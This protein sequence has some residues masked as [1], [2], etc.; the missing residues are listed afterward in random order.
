[1]NL[2]FVFCTTTAVRRGSGTIKKV[3]THHHHG[4]AWIL[5][6]ACARK[7]SVIVVDLTNDPVVEDQKV[8]SRRS[9]GDACF[10]YGSRYFESHQLN[11]M[12]IYLHRAKSLFRTFDVEHV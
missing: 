11:E 12:D 8:D 5:F 2:N 6:R 7:E 1:M 9:V 4:F 3:D 10:E